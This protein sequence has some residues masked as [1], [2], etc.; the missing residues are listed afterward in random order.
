MTSRFRSSHRKVTPPGPTYMNDDQ[1]AQYL[2]DLRT[3]RPAR[4]N[5][6][7]PLPSKAGSG[8]SLSPRRT[9]MPPRASSALSTSR[10]SEHSR[11][12]S[13]DIYPRSNS[14]LSHRRLD[15]QVSLHSPSHEPSSPETT[16]TLSPTPSA[17]SPTSRYQY[18]ESTQRRLQ[19]EEV[20]SIRNALEEMDLQEEEKR[21]H[22]AAQKEATELVMQHQKYG[23]PKR[24]PHT[25][26]KNP[27]LNSAGRFRSPL[28]QGSHTR[29][30]SGSTQSGSSNGSLHG[31]ENRGSSAT[32]SNVHVKKN[33]ILGRTHSLD[34]VD[35][36]VAPADRS[37]TRTLNNGSSRG[38]FKNP[39]DSIYEEPEDSEEK[40]E[41][42]N[43]DN[44]TPVLTAK[45]QNSL[46]RPTR[47]WR[48]SLIASA[49][50]RLSA[51]HTSPST[52]P[53]KPIY[54]SNEFPPSRK[55]D[56]TTPTKNG[57]EIRSDEIRAAT[58]KRL[59][60]RS[61]KLPTPT[62]VSDRPGR[63]IVSFDPD[64]KSSEKEPQP[65]PS[66]TT[67]S[68]PSPPVPTISV[69]SDNDST[70][71]ISVS[72]PSEAE[73]KNK[74]SARPLPTPSASGANARSVNGRR[75]FFKDKSIEI[76]AP[77]SFRSKI[78]TATC[79]SCG[80]PISGRIVTASNHRLHPE[81]FT[82]YHCNTC[83]ECVAFYEEPA[84]KREERLAASDA[85][86]ADAKIPRFYC[87]LDYHE[88][89]SPRCKHCKTPIETEVIV[90]C[91]AEFHP[92]HFFCAECGDPFTS[93]TPFVE[94]DGYAWCLK[95]H[96]RR[97]ASKCQGCKLPVLDEVVISAL[98]GDWHE[99]CFVCHE[100]G[101]GFGPEGRFFVHEGPP[102]RTAKGRQIGGP[103]QLAVC[104]ACEAR[105]L[106]A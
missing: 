45:T 33:G 1:L 86:E 57:L 8:S 28:D 97:T 18:K 72:G 17:R 64:W 104:E 16:R 54:Q 24:D 10:P 56:E 41:N 85:T 75:N 81:C 78:P 96:S 7:R 44:R 12:S 6:S 25:P 102:R 82:C 63:P 5:G 62:A 76:R 79:D 23:L 68:A 84:A 37:W 59:R 70:P 29:S 92:G 103:V 89:F 66:I 58:S 27:D 46:P 50:E 105:R 51:C 11:L 39:K 77:P 31:C 93:T 9:D 34:V 55:T 101:G 19:R 99:K 2:K 43:S 100:C 98:G 3:N 30:R 74:P 87:H 71:A 53:H 15:S 80:L 83:L 94:Q 36:R 73:S 35:E 48:S 4:P 49:K 32:S 20:R 106:K 61:S 47:P 21:L 69:S 42:N 88:L 65:Q 13:G 52:R 60:D 67:K 38:I 95:C 14:A 90:A 26:Y 22:A 40:V 91:G